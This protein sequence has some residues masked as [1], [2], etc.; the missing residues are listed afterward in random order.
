MHKLLAYD[1]G[2]SS[3]TT[4]VEWDRSGSGGRVGAEDDAMTRFAEPQLAPAQMS[5]RH[6][7]EAKSYEKRQIEDVY[8]LMLLV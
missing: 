7:F 2:I 3:S 5:N 6:T 4:E 1:S 8:V